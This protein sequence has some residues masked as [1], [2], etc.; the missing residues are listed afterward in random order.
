M[1]RI[2]ITL[3]ILSLSSFHSL[4]AQ[5]EMPKVKK[6]AFKY[7]IF[8]SLDNH[9]ILGYEHYIKPYKTVEGNLGII[10]I[11]KKY[12]STIINYASTYAAQG[13]FLK[14]AYKNIFKKGWNPGKRALGGTYLKYELAYTFF[15]EQSTGYQSYVP[16]YQLK[17]YETKNNVQA[18]SIM[19]IAGQQ[20]V[21]KNFVLINFYGGLGSLFDNRPFDF[22][23][24]YPQNDYIARHFNNMGRF[25]IDMGMSIGFVF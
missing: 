25:S 6:H 13:L 21:I 17:Y 1:T 20:F 10:G 18:F 14:I 9:I 22:Y 4:I 23:Y 5:N 24:D 16:P 3:L 19:L 12:Q 11:G 7:D 15:K 8:A 2:L